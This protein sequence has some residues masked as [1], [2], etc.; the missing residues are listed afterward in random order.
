[1]LGQNRK[2]LLVFFQQLFPRG[3][4]LLAALADSIA[5]I[6]H[7]FRWDQKLGVFRPAIGALGQTN[8]VFAQGLAVSSFSILFVG[9]AVGNVAIHDNERR[10]IARIEKSSQSARK[11]FQII[12]VAHASHIPSIAQETGGYILS[13]SQSRVTFY[14]DV[15]VIVDP[16]KIGELKMSGE[17]GGFA[18]DTF[19][20][21]AI[22]AQRVDVVVEQ[23]VAGL[24]EVSGEP[25]LGDGHA[26][27]GSN[28]LSERACGGLDTGSPAIFRMAGS[29][30]IKLAEMLDVIQRDRRL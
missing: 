2:F 14:G 10:P 5:E 25:A 4:Q 3:A 12:S 27:A 26:N 8:L 1:M 16:A 6:F 18:R 22:A 28:S 13:K 15:V 30:A 11:H 19:H 21:V 23:F 29:F 24:V 7:H 17:R 9:S 20:H